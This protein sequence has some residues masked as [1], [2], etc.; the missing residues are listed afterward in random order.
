MSRNTTDDISEPILHL[1]DD[2]VVET[3]AKLQRRISERFPGAGLSTLC[4]ELLE[5]AR[6]A[7][8]RSARI[9]HPIL[10]IRLTGYFFAVCLVAL[11]IYII[12]ELGVRPIKEPMSLVESLQATEAATSMMLPIGAALYFLI[13]LETRIKRRRALVAI[14][15]LRSIAHIIDMHQLTKDP[16]RV[17]RNWQGTDNSPKHCMTPL[18]LNRYLDY[19]SEMLSLTGKIAALYV[20]Q[21]D[22]PVAVATVSEVENLTT[23]LSRKIWQ[24]I[25]ILTQMD[26]SQLQANNNDRPTNPPPQSQ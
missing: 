11:L 4:G 14:H 20:R 10:W 24:K 26:E 3:I 8:Q 1:R 25:M 21:F 7:S 16:E 2:H 9:G 18:Q 19:C 22:D 6:R 15:E 23:G 5:I 12:G 13:N 17:L